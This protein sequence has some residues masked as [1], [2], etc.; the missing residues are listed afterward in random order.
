MGDLEI[1]LGEGPSSEAGI[2]VLVCA[3]TLSSQKKEASLFSPVPPPEEVI[4][5]SGSVASNIHIQL[6]LQI[7]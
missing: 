1:A 5:P 2:E 3:E 4:H 7:P 6:R